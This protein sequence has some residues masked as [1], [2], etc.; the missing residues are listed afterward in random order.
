LAGAFFSAGLPQPSATTNM[1]AIN[2]MPNLFI[3]VTSV[4]N[5]VVINA[6]MV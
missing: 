5:D 3:P 2:K 1:A 4:E 6:V